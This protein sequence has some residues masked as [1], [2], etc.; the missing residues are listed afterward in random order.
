MERDAA[1]LDLGSDAAL[2]YYYVEFAEAKHRRR[3]NFYVEE[4]KKPEY[5]VTVKPAAARASGQFRFRPRLRRA[6][7]LA[8]R[9]PT[10]RSSTSCTRPALLVGSGRGGRQRRGRRWMRRDSRRGD[11]DDTYGADRAAG[12]QGVLDANG[13]LTVTLPTSR[14]TASTTTRTTASRRA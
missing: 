3:G 11:S 2:G 4:Y 12:A 10:P 13:R 6:T 14:S 8:S 7:S 9:W 1:D 5:Q